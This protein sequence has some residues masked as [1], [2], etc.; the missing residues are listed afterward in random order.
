MIN[1]FEFKTNPYMMVFLPKNIRC[2]CEGA[3]DER[4]E[5]K[6]RGITAQAWLGDEVSLYP[7]D[8]FLQCKA[9]LSTG[10]RL[11]LLTCNP[12]NIT[13]YLYQD[14]I[15]KDKIRHY[16]FGLDDNPSLS[17]D[18]VND[19]N[20]TYV[21]IQ[22]RWFVQGEWAGDQDS[23]VIPEFLEMQDEIVRPIDLPVKFIPMMS[24][25]VGWR[26]F[27][28]ALFGYWDFVRGKIVIDDEVVIKNRMNTDLLA[29]MVKEKEQEL[30]GRPSE[31]RFTD[32]DLRLVEDMSILHGLHFIPTRKDNKEAQINFLRLCVA[33]KKIEINP[34]C[35]ELIRQLGGAIWNNRRTSYE[36][37]DGFG[38]FDG[39]DSLIYFVRNVVKKNPFPSK[40]EVWQNQGLFISPKNQPDS[41]EWKSLKPNVLTG[42]SELPGS[43]VYTRFKWS[44]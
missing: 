6:I 2:Y 24:L 20:D 13:H 25:D 36:R 29:K 12:G 3:N 4:A 31:S 44:Q 14:F 18:Y 7:K 27:T 10:A 26:D 37:M 22:K 21:G 19:L 41:Q 28:F 9:R 43:T 17:K 42:L 40:E 34:K 5:E 32:V 1:A 35:V 11:G 38:H 30:W 8:F 23:L 33:Q 15:A 16:R 39:V